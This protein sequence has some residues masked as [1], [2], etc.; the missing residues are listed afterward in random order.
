MKQSI[1]SN[2]YTVSARLVHGRILGATFGVVMTLSVLI[3]LGLLLMSLNTSDTYFGKT[4]PIEVPEPS[5]EMEEVTQS[6]SE[7]P[8]GDNSAVVDKE[9]P[10][11]KLTYTS[12]AKAEEPS[13]KHPLQK[14]KTLVNVSRLQFIEPTKVQLKRVETPE[15]QT[16]DV[17]Q[18]V[19]DTPLPSVPRVTAES[20]LSE[21]AS[22]ESGNNLNQMAGIE[23]EGAISKGELT[24]LIDPSDTALIHQ[25]L[26]ESKLYVL[27]LDP[28][29]KQAAYVYTPTSQT[30]FKSGR[31]KVLAKS[32]LVSE[33]S[34][35][36]LDIKSPELH[37][38][39]NWVLLNRKMIRGYEPVFQISN[40]WD[41]KINALHSESQESTTLR[42][43]RKG[44]KV[45][46]DQE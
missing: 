1:L 6:D 45:T 44:G 4:G 18:N 38:V 26:R 28:V 35:R 27:Y 22:M 20:D 34:Q 14:N 21:E 29:T 37:Q 15:P 42:V 11:E 19:A 7:I 13:K 36:Q 3:L 9:V 8:Q 2:P 33:L 16:S 30:D 43:T 41:H 17:E 12:G 5:P 32:G 23:Q 46:L 10:L 40:H 39:F 24:I 25:L 31:V